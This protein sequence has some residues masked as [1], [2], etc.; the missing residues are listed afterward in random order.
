MRSRI[1]CS[2]KNDCQNLLKKIGSQSEIILRGMP[3]SLQ[4][5][6]VKRSAT[7]EA[8][9]F[10]GKAPKWAAFEKRSTR[11]NI[12]VKPIEAGS[13]IIKSRETASKIC[14]GG[15]IGCSK[16]VGA[17]VRYLVY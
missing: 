11:T 3:W 1:P 2:L 7:L 13:L 10:V 14:V 9:K 12:A 5:V 4:I 16:P 6:V 15:V 8:E 17:I